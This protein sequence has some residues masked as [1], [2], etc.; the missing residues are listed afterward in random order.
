MV[1]EESSSIIKHAK[2]GLVLMSFGQRGAFNE[3]FQPK[4]RAASSRLCFVNFN[5]YAHYL[6]FIS[7]Y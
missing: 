7:F 6:K 3:F 5:S 4:N 1:L 2:L